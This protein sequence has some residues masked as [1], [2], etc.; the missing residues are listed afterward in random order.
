MW[1]TNSLDLMMGISRFTCIYIIYND[2]G[3][4]VQLRQIGQGVSKT[5]A[6]GVIDYSSLI[7]I[8]FLKNSVKIFSFVKMNTALKW[9]DKSISFNYR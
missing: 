6:V 8:F 3:C 9:A 4:H 7:I 2:D 1:Q 5:N